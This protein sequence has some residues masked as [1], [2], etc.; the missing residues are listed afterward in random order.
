MVAKLQGLNTASIKF[1]NRLALTMLKIKYDNDQLQN[2]YLPLNTLV[3]LL[4]ILRH[5]MII[6]AQRLQD[7]GEIYKAK[8]Q[9]ECELM[10]LNAPDIKQ[11]E[12]EQPDLQ[13]QV[14]SLAP[15]FGDDYTDLIIMLQNNS[16]VNIHI[17]DTQ[18]ELLLLALSRALN[19]SDDKESIHLIGS[20]LDFI[21]LYVVDL[22]N[23][24]YLNYRQVEHDVWKQNLFLNHL[25]I[26][27]VFETDKGKQIQA[28]TVLKTNIKP[29]T[30]EIENL[31]SRVASLTPAL[32][33]IQQGFPLCQTFYR[34][35]NT[36]KEGVLTKE[37]YL[38]ALHAFCLEMQ[39]SV[40]A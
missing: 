36:D 19:S 22:K 35:I 8:I 14:A 28:G 21:M 7:K 29:G 5:R 9:S 1:N 16:V 37:E 34:Q 4:L 6:I 26:L 39:S 27:Y 20:L 23:L 15:K 25:L 11:D 13:N 17:E 32:Q 40:S 38:R 10:L 24:E 3:D 33:A 2:L 18:I 30:P 12:L 31:V